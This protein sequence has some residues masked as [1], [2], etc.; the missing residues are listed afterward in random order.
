[1]IKCP[2]CE[3]TLVEPIEII[4]ERCGWDLENDMTQSLHLVEV[5]RVAIN[6]LE[7]RLKINRD[8]Y[9]SYRDLQVKFG[10]LKPGMKNL[11]IDGNTYK[12]V[13]LIDKKK[14]SMI[15]AD[16]EIGDCV[17]DPSW[18]WEYRT[19]VNYS[20]QGVVKPVAWIVVAKNHYK[21][22]E[23]HVTLLSEEVVGRYPFDNSTNRGGRFLGHNHWGNSGVTDATCGLRTWLNSS[24]NHSFD[25]F[26]K[27]FSS[28]FKYSILTTEVMNRSWR[29]GFFYTTS[30]KVFIPSS[31]ELG[32]TTHRS[33]LP[34][35]SPYSYFSDNNCSARRISH[36]DGESV[37]YWLRS[38]DSDLGSRVYTVTGDGLFMDQNANHNEGGVRPV[39]NMKS[40]TL[41]AKA[42]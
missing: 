7:H 22:I 27:S 35:G 14:G 41:V 17:I 8:I 29:T 24:G 18:Q 10:K 19:G 6:K 32:D 21:G 36:L 16:M 12:N 4:C 37:W 34:I 39:V 3:K 26:S 11:F 28:S 31:T 30:E 20:G 42:E 33:T 9:N 15:L 1:L 23:P 25:G 40:N 13:Y 2:V 5:K 38:P